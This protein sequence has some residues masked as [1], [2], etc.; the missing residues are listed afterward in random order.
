MLRVW[1]H[2]IPASRAASAARTQD[3]PCA[4]QMV[5]R[6]GPGK[7][8]LDILAHAVFVIGGVDPAS[9]RWQLWARF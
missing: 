8:G 2:R 7:V 1:W 9:K 5:S 4:L 6:Q 3:L